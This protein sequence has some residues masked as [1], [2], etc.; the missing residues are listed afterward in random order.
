VL[1]GGRDSVAHNL[2]TVEGRVAALR[3]AAPVVASIRDQA[4][5]IGYRRNLAGWLGMDV[6]E[7]TRAV[8]SVG[9]APR[10][11][12]ESP[13]EAPSGPTLTQL[14]TDPSTRLERDVIMAVLQHPTD[15]GR[16]MI[17]RI[18]SIRF[19]DEALSVVRDAIATSVEHYESPT[20]LAQIVAEVPTHYSTLVQQLGM[21]PIPA[22]ESA[23]AAYCQSVAVAIV[24]RDLLRRKKELVGALQRTD[25]AADAT[26]YQDLQRELVAIET[27][28]RLIR[29]D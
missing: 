16:P 9:Q 26:K 11:A 1:D 24:D 29:P 25:S 19:G 17:E 18:A 3:E 14:A 15:V 5:A 21:A 6:E 2:E 20:W 22:R 4:L 8:R 23:M 28:R 7:V 12:G 13:A 27:S 10:S